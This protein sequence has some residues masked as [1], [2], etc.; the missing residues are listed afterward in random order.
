MIIDSAAWDLLAKKANMP[1][2]QLLGL[3]KK[4]IKTSITVSIGEPDWVYERAKHL[5]KTFNP[6][7]LKIKLGSNAGIEPDQASFLAVKQAVLDMNQPNHTQLFVDAN[8]G[9]D[10]KGAKHMMQWLHQQGA[11]YVEQPLKKGEESYLPELFQDRPLPIYVD[12]SIHFVSDIHN[13]FGSVDGVNL[14]LNKS[15]GITEALRIYNIARGFNLKC[16]IGCFSESPHAIA[17]AL[18]IGSLFDYVDLDSFLN[19]KECDKV[20]KDN[21]LT[22]KDGYLIQSNHPGIGVINAI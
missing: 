14:K 11:I 16:M 9:W 17:T 4:D 1:L 22:Y 21:H 15:G 10:V 3:E 2:Y 7:F 13:V 20:S 12:E 18:S 6:Y 19:L 5:I 8:G